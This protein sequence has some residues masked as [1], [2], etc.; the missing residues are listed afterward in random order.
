MTPV[1]GGLL[2]H[3]CH[4]NAGCF[5][6]AFGLLRPPS[7]SETNMLASILLEVAGS[8]AAPVIK[9]ILDDKLG[10]AGGELAGRV[11]DI[12]AEKAAFR[13]TNWPTRRT[14]QP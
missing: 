2:V 10:G 8:L 7:S 14:C 13:S 4:Q 11:V 6:L 5:A 9:K 1:L 3:I 12:I